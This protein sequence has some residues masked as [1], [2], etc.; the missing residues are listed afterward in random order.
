MEPFR[1]TV[2]PLIVMIDDPATGTRADSL[3]DDTTDR[4]PTGPPTRAPTGPPTR[5]PTAAPTLAPAS[6]P[7]QPPAADPRPLVVA[8]ATFSPSPMEGLCESFSHCS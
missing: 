7:A 4:A 6:P 3:A 8:R 2:N 5:A 1:N